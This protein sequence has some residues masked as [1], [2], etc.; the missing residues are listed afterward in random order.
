MAS[1]KEDARLP[2]L[3]SMP[4]GPLKGVTCDRRDVTAP[5][6]CAEPFCRAGSLLTRSA[7][8]DKPLPEGCP[9]ASPSRQTVGL[10]PLSCRPNIAGLVVG[11]Q[12]G[13]RTG[14]ADLLW[15][16]PLPSPSLRSTWTGHLPRW[17][18]ADLSPD[19]DA[20]SPAATTVCRPTTHAPPP[21]SHSPRWAVP[22]AHN[23][24]PGCEHPYAS[25]H[26]VLALTCPPDVARQH[27][28]RRML[29]DDDAK[30]GSKASASVNAT[31][32]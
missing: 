8:E 20:M 11:P 30:Q 15:Y 9:E 1:E 23:L 32:H 21:G 26:A 5:S 27:A 25:R 16:T 28:A 12:N 31:P 10:A 22:P 6:T 4:V 7:G 24:L 2:L 29:R 19:D 17:G 13:C 3:T 18:R 14:H